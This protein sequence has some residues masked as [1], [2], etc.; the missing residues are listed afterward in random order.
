M[1]FRNKKWFPDVEKTS[2]S[3]EYCQQGL[4]FAQ[5]TVSLN[6]AFQPALRHHQ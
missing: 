1:V 6:P 3:L 5:F 4:K 2:R